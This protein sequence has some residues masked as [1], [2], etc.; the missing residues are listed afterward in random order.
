MRDYFSPSQLLMVSS[1]IG[2]RT[3]AVFNFDMVV[4]SFLVFLTYRFHLYKQ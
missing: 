4:L 3:M 1:D 2:R